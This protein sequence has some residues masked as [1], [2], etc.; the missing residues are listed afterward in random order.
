MEPNTSVPASLKRRFVNW[1]NNKETPVEIEIVNMLHWIVGAILLECKNLLAEDEQS[2]I[3]QIIARWFGDSEPRVKK[4]VQNGLD[5]LLFGWEN[6]EYLYTRDNNKSEEQIVAK[7]RLI[8]SA[9]ENKAKRSQANLSV[10]NTTRVIGD[11]EFCPRI[12]QPEDEYWKGAYNSLI[13]FNKQNYR[14]LNFDAPGRIILCEPFF[15]NATDKFQT[16]RNRLHALIHELTH[17]FLGTEDVTVKEK[18]EIFGLTI[19]EPKEAYGKKRCRKLADSK[20][21]LKNALNNADNWAYFIMDVT[22]WYP[23]ESERTDTGNE[24]P[25]NS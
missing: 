6:Y 15:N 7:A 21:N 22:G 14:D 24:T 17:T 19:A 12:E 3:D 10:D 1:E 5:K 8:T 20:Y 2:N 13:E 4:R 18:W 25:E 23:P 9:L 16:T 11:F